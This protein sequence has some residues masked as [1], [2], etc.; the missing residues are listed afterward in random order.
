MKW[1]QNV[2]IRQLI[3]A[4]ED[5]TSYTHESCKQNW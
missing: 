2:K 5:M 3:G 4:L 1:V